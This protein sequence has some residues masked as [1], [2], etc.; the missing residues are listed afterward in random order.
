MSA[1]CILTSM[2]RRRAI[3]MTVG[4]LGLILSCVGQNTAPQDRELLAAVGASTFTDWRCKPRGARKLSAGFRRDHWCLIEQRRP[5]L[6]SATA[7][8]RDAGGRVVS[9]LRTWSTS[10]SAVWVRLHD[11]VSAA[12][13]ERTRTAMR[14]PTGIDSARDSSRL[15]RAHAP[16]HI[17]TKLWRLPSYDLVQTTNV[18]KAWAHGHQRWWS[19]NVEASTYELVLCGRRPT[20]GAQPGRR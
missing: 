5:E 14:C 6:L 16:H 2:S 15:G 17:A 9:V 19:M 1:G 10:D 20:S 3:I 7:L 12:L 13:A 18:P 11:S 8:T 4:T